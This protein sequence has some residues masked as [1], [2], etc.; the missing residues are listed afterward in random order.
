MTTALTKPQKEA[1]ETS[2]R[3]RR[4]TLLDTIRTMLLDS[5]DQSFTE[6][7]GRV[8]DTGDESV[9][10][11]LA[12][13]M[14]QRA[15]HEI[16]ELRA[17]EAA[18]A[19]LDKGSYGTCVDCGEHIAFARLEASPTAIRCVACQSRYEHSHPEATPRL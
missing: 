10:D 7:A 1:L 14:A 8:H 12:D 15:D 16:T 17:T 2:L 18:L 5:G 13:A 19:R 4:G 9:A 6:L 3:E 11:T